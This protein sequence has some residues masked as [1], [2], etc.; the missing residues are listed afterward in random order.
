MNIKSI[1]AKHIKQALT[2]KKIII[3]HDLMIF[4]VS[5]KKKWDYQVNGIIKIAKNLN[6][7]PYSISQY[8]AFNINSYKYNIYNKIEVSKL[9]FINIFINTDWIEKKILQITESFRLGVKKVK[10]QKIIIDYSSPNIAKEMHVGHLRSTILG[11]A[12]ARMMEFLG[13]TVIRIN[14]IGDWGTHFGIV[15]AYLKKKS[16]PYKEIDDIDLD[17]LYQHAK[18]QFDTDSKFSQMARKYVVK[19]Q[20]QDQECIQIWK[21][22]VKYT[23]VKNEKIYKKLNVTLRNEHIIGESFYKNMLPEIV[24]DLKDKKIAQKCNG[25]LIVFLNEFK[26]RHNEPMGVLVKKDDNAFLYATIDLASLRYRCKTLH[27]DQILYYIDSRQQQYLQQIF[28]IAKKAKYI[29]NNII[30]KH[31]AF[32]MICSDNKKPFKT[33]SGKNVK[34]FKLLNEAIKRAKEITKDKN[35]NLSEKQLNYLSE[36]IGI[37][38]VKYFDLSK[39]RLTN[40]VFKWDKILSFDGNTA[41]YMQYAYI[42]ILSIFRKLNISVLKLTGKIKLLEEYERKLAIKLLQ[43]EEIL[44]ESSENGIPHIMCKY[45]YELS[46]IFSK[47]YEKHSILCSSN[48]KIRNSRLLLSLLTART[49]KKGLF[50]IGISTIKYM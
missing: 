5:D 19:L 3:S 6:T 29:S 14:H 1:I 49:L 15:I 7:N 32:G 12:T 31:H 2:Y 20:N 42:R 37:G 18:K 4:R 50:L 39:N 35:K 28:K 38:A 46:T 13:H 47:F 34:L 24:S 21:K 23:I 44:L 33:R 17:Q 9:G 48:N 16:I 41:P 36:K 11:D 27:A 45:L 22:I 10:P 25:A 30:L 40:Y 26:N 43:F 8:V